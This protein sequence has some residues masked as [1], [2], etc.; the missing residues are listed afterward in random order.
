MVQVKVDHAK[1]D[2]DGTC[3]SVC[4]VAVFEI[5]EVQGKKK[6]V[7]IN[8]DACIVCRACEAQCP[9]QAIVVTE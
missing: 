9:Q 7:V 6:A 4:P 1:C 3:V 2:G 5:Q 8:N